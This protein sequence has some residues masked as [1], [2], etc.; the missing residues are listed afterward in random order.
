M[1]TWGVDIVPDTNFFNG[2]T[3]SHPFNPEKIG[4][5]LID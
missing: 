3:P 2:T 5:N 1:S 4:V